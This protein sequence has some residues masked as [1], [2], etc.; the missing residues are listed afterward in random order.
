MPTSGKK[1]L[2]TPQQKAIN[3]PMFGGHSHASNSPTK[4]DGSSEAWCLGLSW[5]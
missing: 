1:S 2:Q 4:Q 3:I 5:K